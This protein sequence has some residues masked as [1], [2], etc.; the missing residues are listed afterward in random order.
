VIDV[1]AGDVFL[2][3]GQ[4]NSV[5]QMYSGNANAEQSKWVRSF[6]TRAAH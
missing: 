3:D 2:T 4:S 5:A 1:V 6:S